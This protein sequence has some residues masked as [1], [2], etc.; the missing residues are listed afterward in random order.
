MSDP[1]SPCAMSPPARP[2]ITFE[3]VKEQYGWAIRNDRLMIMPFWRRRDAVEEALR[4]AEELRRHGAPAEVWVE[5]AEAQGPTPAR[6][7]SFEQPNTS[8][9]RA[10]A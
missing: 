5:D 3:V 6:G 2:A 10:T 4:V 9:K 1:K 7:R 8:C